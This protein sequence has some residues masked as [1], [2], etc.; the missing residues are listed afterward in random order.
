MPNE[1]TYFSLDMF[2]GQEIKYKKKNWLIRAETPLGLCNI[3]KNWNKQLAM[4]TYN[5]KYSN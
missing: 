3:C 4:I 2:S 5:Y 1:N